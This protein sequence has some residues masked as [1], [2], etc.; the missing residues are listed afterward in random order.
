MVEW[1][2]M[3]FLFAE[4]CGSIGELNPATTLPLIFYGVT[5]VLCEE[6]VREETEFY[7]AVALTPIVILFYLLDRRHLS[8]AGGYGKI[9]ILIFPITFFTQL[10]IIYFYPFIAIV[11]FIYLMICKNKFD[12]KKSLLTVLIPFEKNPAMMYNEM[13]NKQGNHWIVDYIVAKMMKRG[14]QL[15]TTTKKH[16][17]QFELSIKDVYVA[18]N[19][20]MMNNEKIQQLHE[21]RLTSQGHA[22]SSS[23]SNV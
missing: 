10:F 19:E 16:M 1:I 22:P 3:T 4:V 13:I 17:G 14:T 9:G 18:S 11:M 15:I 21:L 6:S 8:F 12:V 2:F 20:N 23:G 5:S 7:F